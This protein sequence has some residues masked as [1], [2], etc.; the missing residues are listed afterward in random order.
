M[1]V[2]YTAIKNL[3][4]IIWGPVEKS[5]LVDYRNYPFSFDGK[6]Q[7]WIVIIWHDTRQWSNTNCIRKWQIKD[8]FTYLQKILTPM[9]IITTIQYA[10]LGSHDNRQ[11][12][13]NQISRQSKHLNL[14]ICV[15]LQ[16]PYGTYSAVFTPR[17]VRPGPRAENFIRNKNK[18]L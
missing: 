14:S 8:H 15:S 5:V 4:G 3:K 18:V 16:K 2:C 10:S 17:P 13:K 1:G 7:I 6:S 11:V 9:L 12:P